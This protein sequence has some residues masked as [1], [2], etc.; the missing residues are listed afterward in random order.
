MKIWFD[1]DALRGNHDFN[2][3]IKDTIE[4]SALFFILNSRSYEKSKYCRQELEWFIEKNKN[5]PEGLMVGNSIRSFNILLNNIPHTEWP[6]I[7]QGKM[8][9]KFHDAPEKSTD[10]GDRLE[11]A[12][13]QFKQEFSQLVK[14]TVSTLEALESRNQLFKTSE[15]SD[16]EI[17]KPIIF[18][19]DV[20]DTLKPFREKLTNELKTEARVLPILPPPYEKVQH[21]KHLHEA[22]NRASMSIHLLDQWGGALVE[23][24]LSNTFPR[25][26]ADAARELKHTAV[27]WI[28]QSIKQEDFEDELQ[29]SWL[30]K[31]EEQERPHNNFHL[32]RSSRQE[33]IV[34][35]KQMLTMLNQQ[36]VSI[37]NERFIIDTH[38]KDQKHAYLLAALLTAQ[39][40]D[41]DFNKESDEPKDNIEI[42]EKNICEAQ[43]LIITF[44]QVALDWVQRRIQQAMHV[45]V[46]LM[47]ESK[48]SA[49]I[50]VFMP[51]GFSELNQL[52]K[53]PASIK[54]NYLMCNNESLGTDS[55]RPLLDYRKGSS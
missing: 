45:I 44:G 16:Y 28:P 22:L 32:V 31:I 17:E 40:L 51:P 19:A 41:V 35:I 21:Q 55:L 48:E 53:I 42:F 26:Q 2:A 33:L 5:K 39:G 13:H 27:L 6:E 43:H 20:S 23:N 8:C 34:Q 49:V 4:S 29:A 46:R 54:I 1:D 47:S 9:L 11:I 24:D 10:F 38:Q 37:S 18:M 7:L 36:P 30:K 25:V 14:S 15:K 50:W 52:P 12:S 3:E